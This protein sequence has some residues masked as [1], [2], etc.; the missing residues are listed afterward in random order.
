MA[1]YCSENGCHAVIEKGMFCA[2]HQRKRK[3]KPVYSKNRSFYKT[4]AWKD[5]C[6]YIR[7]R[8]GLRC[9]RCHKVVVGKQ[10]HVHHIEPIW[11]HP[12]L[13]LEPSNLI[14]VCAKCHP[15]LEKD[16][17]PPTKNKS[18]KYFWG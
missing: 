12:E 17:K 5:M 8:D 1:K 7:Q 16:L 9:Q 18:E 4:K 15:I 2:D 14:L 13:K 6:D 11:K 3:Q 10:A